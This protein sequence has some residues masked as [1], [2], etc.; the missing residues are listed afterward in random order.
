MSNLD[1]VVLNS[2]QGSELQDKFIGLCNNEP[3]RLNAFIES[4]E[5]PLNNF[6]FILTSK[7]GVEYEFHI[8]IEYSPY[9]KELRVYDQ[10]HGYC[11][12]MRNMHVITDVYSAHRGSVNYEVAMGYQNNYAKK[13]LEKATTD[14]TN[15]KT[16][17]DW[18]RTIC[19]LF[20][21]FNIVLLALPHKLIS[22]QEKATKTI[23][24]KKNG[25]T[26]YKSVVYLR[27]SYRLVDNFKLNKTDI[28]HIIKCPAWGVR[29]HQR[30]YSNGQ[31]VFI[32]PYR[33]GKFR[34]DNKMLVSKT[35]KI[36]K[37]E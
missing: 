35:Y 19:V 28:K 14:T 3:Q 8:E 15:L 24:Q 34:N 30:H 2:D 6:L 12:K 4:N 10:E 36:D 37:G 7:H 25:R 31:V 22:K 13:V 21:S 17:Q 26:T 32:K 29:G 16:P 1:V 9:T 23:E 5:F 33:K 11:A 20:Y 18:I 27:N